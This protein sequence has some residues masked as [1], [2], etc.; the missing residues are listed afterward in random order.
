[1]RNT[2]W[3]MYCIPEGRILWGRLHNLLIFGGPPRGLHKGHCAFDSS[4][5]NVFFIW[6][7]W[8]E[9][10]WME[11]VFFDKIYMK[12]TFWG[13]KP[14]EKWASHL[15]WLLLVRLLS[16]LWPTDLGKTIIQHICATLEYYWHFWQNPCAAQWISLSHKWDSDWRVL[17]DRGNQ[18]YLFTLTSDWPN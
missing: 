11:M 17:K 13:A 4:P 2:V 16:V 8:T 15:I 3:Y 1:M 12:A 6:L 18:M 5:I 9:M 7:E 14:M 10:V